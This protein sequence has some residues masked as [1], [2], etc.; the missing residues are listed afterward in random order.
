MRTNTDFMHLEINGFLINKP[1]D[2]AEAF[3]KLIQ[4]VYSNSSCLEPFLLLL[5]LR[6]FYP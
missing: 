2:I 3:S 5:N 1:R 4:S 6:K